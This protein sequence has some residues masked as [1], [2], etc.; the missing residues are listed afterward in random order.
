MLSTAELRNLS[1]LVTMAG[2]F[3]RSNVD[4]LRAEIEW[5][6]G[7][8]SSV[9]FDFEKVTFVNGAVLSLLRDVLERVGEDGWVGVAR[10]RQEILALFAVAGLSF[11]PNFRVFSTL[12]EA[13]E[14]ID[15]R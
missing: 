1:C 15:Q 8:A 5:C 10:P 14:V 9:V 12:E 11:L 3:D 4:A 2:E 13:L 6:L 7:S